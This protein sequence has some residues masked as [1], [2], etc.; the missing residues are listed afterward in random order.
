MA[1]AVAAARGGERGGD[2]LSGRVATPAAAARPGAAPG[3]TPA[4]RRARRAWLRAHRW[5]GLTA[6]L[7]FVLL[8]LTGSLLVFYPRL[9][10]L[11]DPAHVVASGGR[12]VSLGA[13]VAAARAAHRGTAEP[14]W[15][16][17]PDVARGA[18]VVR[19]D[20]P[21]GARGKVDAVW[22]AVDPATGRAMGERVWGDYAA[23]WLYELHHSLHLGDAGETAVGVVGLLVLVSLGSGAYLWWPAVRANARRALTVHRRAGGARRTRDL[24]NAG[25]VYAGVVLL[26]V[27]LSGAYLVFAGYVDPLVRRVARVTPYPAGLTSALRPG[28]RPVSPDQAVAAGAR[29]MSG[30]ELRYLALP[31]GPTGVYW[32]ITRPEGEAGRKRA[33]SHAWVDQYSGQVLAVRDWRRAT[34]ADRVLASMLPVHNGE[35][36]GLAGRLAVAASGVA[37][38]LLYVTG[39]RMWWRKRR[40][41]QRRECRPARDGVWSRVTTTSATTSRRAAPLNSRGGVRARPIRASGTSRDAR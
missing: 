3:P 4:W 18:Y 25:G 16:L 30:G 27:A 13:I 21:R 23:S 12:R 20:E 40:G 39:V 17:A 35:V 8:G 41:R 33:Q 11:A 36:L 15:I 7:V 9:D 19:F 1:A 31:A 10:A 22:A 29:A 32:V 37:P 38:L 5:L 2:V 26:A 14:T 34:A 28:A 24:H 6:G